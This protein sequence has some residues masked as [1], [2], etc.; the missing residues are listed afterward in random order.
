KPTWGEV[1]S[2]TI[3]TGIYLLEPPIFDAIPAGQEYDFG[4]DLFPALLTAGR[5]VAG[6]VAEGYWRDVG[7]LVEY[8]LAHIDLIAR[9]VRW[10][11]SGARVAGLD[12]EVWLDEEARVDF[13]AHLGGAVIVGRKARVEP[14]A[15]IAQ[16]VI[17]PGCVIGEGAVLDGCVVW[18]GAEIGPRAVLKECVVG[19]HAII[20]ADATVQEG[21]VIS[22]NC[23]VGPR[24]SFAPRSGP[25]RPRGS[26][27]AQRWR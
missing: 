2:D 10:S 7:D 20:R 26:R 27:T 12:R 14:N 8:R 13:T 4:K 15:R 24:P 11:P 6:H 23:R 18:E 3:N 17:G 19:R 16:S 1:F 22:D 9:P 25:G 21:A 5:P